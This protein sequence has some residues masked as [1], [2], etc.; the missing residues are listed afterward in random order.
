MVFAETN[1]LR[2]AL[3]SITFAALWFSGSRSGW[4]SLIGVLAAALYIGAI[5]T[6]D[7]TCSLGVASVIAGCITAIAFLHSTVPQTITPLIVPA[8]ASTSERMLT[9]IEGYKLFAEHPLF[10]AGLGSFRNLHLLAAS[11]TPL[12]I[13]ST[14]LWLLAELG[15]VGF[16]G[17]VIPFALLFF[18][19]FKTARKER[20]STLIVLCIITFAMMSIPADMLYQ[21]T[22]WL[23]IGAAVALV[24]GKPN[25][26]VVLDYAIGSR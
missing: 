16:L 11:G 4:M 26:P 22:F 20:A 12:L 23:L 3:L 24:H 2:T 7:L 21:R 1:K 13:H 18:K 25:K 17:F 14:G 6:R 5:R 9:W 10:G 8:S 19:E 15:V